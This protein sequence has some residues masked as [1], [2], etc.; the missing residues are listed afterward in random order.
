MSLFLNTL[1]LGGWQN[2]VPTAK[3]YS[4]HEN[5]NSILF[6]RGAVERVVSLGQ[7]QRHVRHG[8]PDSVT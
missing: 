3:T 5:I 4:L 1:F 8:I 6:V 7:M 2:I